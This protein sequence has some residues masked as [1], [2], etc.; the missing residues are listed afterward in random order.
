MQFADDFLIGE[1]M[2]TLLNEQE[3][4][5]RI[6]SHIDNKTTDLGEAVWRE[7]V[8]SYLSDERFESEIALLRR[9]PIPFCP[10]AILPENGSFIT[11][12]A[13]GT[14][15]I[16]VR[17]DDGLVRAFI[18]ACRHRGMPVANDSGCA[19]AFV[20]PYH[21]WTY[22]LDGQLKN[23]PGRSGF[24]GVELQ[25]NGLVE[26]G[27]LEK[28][29]LVYVNQSGPIDLAMLENAPDFFTHEQQVFDKSD[30][31]DEANWKLIAETTM[32][33]YHIKSLHKHSFYPYGL[34]NI[35]VVENF[36][37]NSRVT[38]PFRRI[39]KLRDVDPEER[40]LDGMVTS[41]YQLFPNV[42]VS[43]LSKHST[44]TVFEPL[45]PSRTQML[46][47]R[48]TNKTSDGS[49]TDVA[50][51]KRDAVFVKAAGFDEDRAAA[52]SI[53]GSLGSKANQ[54][55]TFGHFEKAI[56]HFHKNMAAH[57]SG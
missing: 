2:I 39:D 13:A 48:V 49:T 7:P 46:I 14:P 8:A 40:R 26:V 5:E 10:S 53:Q 57:L 16:V 37:S 21:A 22:G 12:K 32:E 15:L 50:E 20:C 18:N 1:K 44:V 4:I 36:D 27:A 43:I 51:A 25:E 19:R 3:I 28:G 24:P 47:Y 23:I 54:H 6:L 41:V 35:N 29:G 17:G 38:F 30:Y 45:S 11:R 9:M 31:T 42:V 55:L 34:D 56:V 52:C 33:G